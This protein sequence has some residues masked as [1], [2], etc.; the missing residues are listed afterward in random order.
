MGRGKS[1]QINHMF[2]DQKG[3]AIVEI[4]VA[5]GLLSVLIVSFGKVMDLANRLN[6][7]AVIRTRAEQLAQGPIE[8]VI[9]KKSELFSLGLAGDYYIDAAGSWQALAIGE[10]ENLGGPENF[11]RKIRIAN[12]R[13]DALTGNISEAGTEDP[14]TK[15]ITVTAWYSDRGV[16]NSVSLKTALTNWE[17]L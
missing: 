1:H 14:G 12:A 10:K 8:A 6:R 7:T 16:E 15:I 5:I 2:K 17:N 3:M 4:L 13:R 11:M 9:S